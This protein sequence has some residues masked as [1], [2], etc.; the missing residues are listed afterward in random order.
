MN[1]SSVFIRLLRHFWN[2][3]HCWHSCFIA[4][5]AVW[6]SFGDVVAPLFAFLAFLTPAILCGEHPTQ[7]AA[8][9]SFFFL[10]PFRG[11]VDATVDGE[12]VFVVV[13]N[14]LAAPLSFPELWRCVTAAS[15]WLSS[16]EM[17]PPSASLMPSSF[18]SVSYSGNSAFCGGGGKGE[19]RLLTKWASVFNNASFKLSLF[20]LMVMLLLGPV[21]FLLLILADCLVVV[22]VVVIVVVVVLFKQAYMIIPILVDNQ[23]PKTR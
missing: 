6:I 17:S 1:V 18:S 9:S 23:Q 3:W 16:T 12:V 15:S 21:M 10:F 2:C 13:A 7:M 11:A 4:A 19:V 8:T 5:V 14:E 22:V 20:L